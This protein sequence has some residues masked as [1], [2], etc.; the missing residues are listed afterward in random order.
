MSAKDV[1]AYKK[2]LT[3]AERAEIGKKIKGARDLG[4]IQ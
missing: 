3:A 4:L 1:A 2:S